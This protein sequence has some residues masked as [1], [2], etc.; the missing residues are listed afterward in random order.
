[1][2]STRAAVVQMTAA[3]FDLAGNAAVIERYLRRAAADG[4]RLVVLPE[5]CV[6][7]YTVA[8]ELADISDPIPGPTGDR[9]AGLAAALDLTVVTAIATRGADGLLRD[10][11]VVVTPDGIA[12][13]GA[14]RCLWGPEPG[15]FAPGAPHERI[16]ADTPV[17]RVGVA[18]C[19]EAGFPEVVRQLALDGAEIIAVPAAF[20]RARLHAWTLMTRSRALEN[21]CYLLA[22]NAAG[23]CGGFDFGGHSTIVDPHGGRRALLADGPGTLVAELDAAQLD[24]ARTAIPYLRDLSACAP[25]ALATTPGSEYRS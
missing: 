7:G 13:A 11:G 21:G 15:I 24:A 8:P 23:P 19:Y 17:G 3:P 25:T 22:A 12:A 9:L 5:L 1:M 16:V 4:A 10:T 2:K 18:I 20:G 14:K 6:T